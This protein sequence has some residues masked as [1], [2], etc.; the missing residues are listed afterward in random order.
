MQSPAECSA[1]SDLI[2]TWIPPAIGGLVAAVGLLWRALLQSRVRETAAMQDHI[3]SLA[4]IS[5]LHRERRRAARVSV[6]RGSDEC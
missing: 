1:Y 5:Q 6:D 3:R 2:S 4:I